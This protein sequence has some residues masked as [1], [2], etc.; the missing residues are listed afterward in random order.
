MSGCKLTFGAALRQSE[1]RLNITA[2]TV[3]LPSFRRLAAPRASAVALW[4]LLM[5][6]G[7]G[8]TPGRTAEPSA[9]VSLFNSRSY[10]EAEAAFES[11]L[12]ANSADA[13]A[14]HYLGRLSLARQLPEEAMPHLE[15]AAA[16]APTKAE[17]QFYYGSGAVQAAAKLGVSFK[18]L[19]LAKKGRIAMEK[20]V[21]LD[22]ANVL[23]RQ[24]LIEFYSQAP[25]IAGGG[26]AKAY[27]QTDV[28]RAHDARAATLGLAGLK[29]REKKY[30]EAIALAEEMIKA[31][32]DDYQALYLVGRLSA[33]SGVSLDRGIAALRAC[34]KLTPPPR[35]V[36][37][38]TVN[39]RLGQALAKSGDKDSARS[40]FAAVLEIDP[41]HTGAKAAL[42]KSESN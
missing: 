11:R 31:A 30:A 22:P 19:G 40:A 4:G 29:A 27:A 17:Y 21:D 24:A 37:H 5:A 1:P 28:L 25:A 9:A 36:S 16:L 32:P 18:A 15:R 7:M 39:Y 13:E 12:S 26:L 6:L 3:S 41:H 20:A 38:A 23:Y 14:H 42:S 33:E 35:T 34:L 2:V 8:A 10:P